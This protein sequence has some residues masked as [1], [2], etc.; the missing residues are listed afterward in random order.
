MT[1][2]QHIVGFVAHLYAL[3]PDEGGRH[4][5]IFNGYIVQSRFTDD[6]PWDNDVVVRLKGQAAC[7]PGD[8]CIAT[9]EF[10]VPDAVTVTVTRGATFVLREGAHVVV[11]GTVQQVLYSI[12]KP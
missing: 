8:E 11:R 7:A 4:W 1:E 3:R 6:Q 9:L 2:G 10:V 5:P 12:D